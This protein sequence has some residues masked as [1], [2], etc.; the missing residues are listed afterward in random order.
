MKSNI[1]NLNSMII[2]AISIFLIIIGLA[3]SSN[4][5]KPTEKVEQHSTDIS[6]KQFIKKIA[7]LAKEDQKNYKISASITI[8]QAALESN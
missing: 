2:G 5:N 1:K 7:P 4:Q 6:N 8:A 3:I